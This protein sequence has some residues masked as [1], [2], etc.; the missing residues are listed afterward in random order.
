MSKIQAETTI[1]SMISDKIIFRL[2]KMGSKNAE[3]K[4]PVE[5]VLNATATLETL[6]APKKAIQ[7]NPMIAPIP[8]N[9]VKSLV[10]NFRLIFFTFKITN[11]TKAATN[12]RYQTNGIASMEINFP[13][14]PV[15]PQINTM[16][17]SRNCAAD[18]N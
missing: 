13:K 14:T 12:T 15:N 16:N 1:A 11:K 4:A 10:D 5:S 18:I 7:C 8:N 2:K 9:I 3:N 6:I 17:C